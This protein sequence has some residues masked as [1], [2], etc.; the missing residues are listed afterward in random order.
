[1]L[2]YHLFGD[3]GESTHFGELLGMVYFGDGVCG[4]VWVTLVLRQACP[5]LVR[6]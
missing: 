6:R 4:G 3:P 2:L 5:K 1:M